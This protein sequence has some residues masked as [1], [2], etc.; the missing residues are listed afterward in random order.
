MASI[1][2]R[3][4]SYAV[5]YTDTVDEKKKQKWETYYSLEDAQQRKELLKLCSNIRTEVRR[6]CVQTVEQFLRNM[7]SYME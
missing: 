1:V 4:K 2:K 6:Q 5:V 3:G 7:W